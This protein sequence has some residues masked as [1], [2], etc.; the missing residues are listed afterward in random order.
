MIIVHMTK[1][2]WTTEEAYCHLLLRCGHF[3]TDQYNYS[4][5]YVVLVLVVPVGNNY[6]TITL[7]NLQVVW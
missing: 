1:A 5:I 7:L 6:Q 2:H 3:M 4:V